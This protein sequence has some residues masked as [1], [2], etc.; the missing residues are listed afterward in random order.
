MPAIDLDGVALHHEAT[1]QGPTTLVL[2]HGS[3]GSSAVWAHQLSGLADV[4]RVV[5]PDLPGHGRSGGGAPAAID[6]SVEI[7]RRLLDALGLARAVVGGHSMGGAVAQAFALA[8]PDRVTGLVLV[9]TGA[10]LKVLPSIFEALEKDYAAGVR[11]VTDLAVG[12]SA[13]A[14][15]KDSIYRLTL[16]TPYRVTAADFGACHVFDVIERLATITAPTLV[17][18]GRDDQLTPPKYAEFLR[19]RIAGAR[20]AVIPGAGHYVQLERPAETT[21]VLREF[22]LSLAEGIR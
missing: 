4:A 11:L 9:G 6:E 12:P 8:H 2:V 17:V 5:A 22:L 16:A 21:A 18:V 15:L 19:T 14:E 1:G 10:R 20:L 13:S 7:V 3:G